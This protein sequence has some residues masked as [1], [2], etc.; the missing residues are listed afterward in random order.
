MVRVKADI[1]AF[2]PDR[3]LIVDYPGFNLRM[4]RWAREQDSL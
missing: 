3:I 4:A 1:L 2:R